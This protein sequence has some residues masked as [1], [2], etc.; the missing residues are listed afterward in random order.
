MT[1]SYVAM[2][3]SPLRR[4]IA[5]RMTEATRTIPHFRLVGD[6]E[7]DAMLALRRRLRH[8]DSQANVSLNDLIIKAC[9]CALMEV[10]AI[11]VQ[12]VEDEIRQFR[13]ADIS[14]VTAIAGGLSTPII[15]GAQSKTVLEIAR[16]VRALTARAACNALRMD[17]IVGGSFIISNL[18]MYGV[19]EIDSINNPPQCAIIAIGCAKPLYVLAPNGEARI[20]TVLRATL[21]VDHRALDGATAA[22][23]LA[24]FRRMVEQPAGLVADVGSAS[25]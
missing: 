24:A 2:T 10:P 18:G 22:G 14:V 13:S 17:E 25:S 19:D 12:W 1:E 15:R 8:A 23:F 21:S 4:I 9:A 7:V 20:A 5:T 16:E 11:N 6:V 3:L